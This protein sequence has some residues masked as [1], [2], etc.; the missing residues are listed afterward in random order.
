MAIYSCRAQTVIPGGR[1]WFWGRNG[2]VGELSETI[3]TL[4]AG[5]EWS[6]PAR[7]NSGQQYS[8]QFAWEIKVAANETPGTYAITIP[9]TVNTVSVT[10]VA[11]PAVRPVRYANTPNWQSIQTWL[12]AG[13]DIELTQ[14]LYRCD[15][16]LL[17]PD[18]AKV[19]SAGGALILR[20]AQGANPHDVQ[21][22]NILHVFSKQWFHR[23]N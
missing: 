9:G 12:L 14:R 16:P 10:V 22:T 17:V 8:R 19:F 13:F 3:P 23:I 2:L 15:C 5:W 7:M 11:A 20:V 6:Y 21:V 1:C 4:R 18:G